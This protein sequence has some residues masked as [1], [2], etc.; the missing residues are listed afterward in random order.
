MV[1]KE[2]H[3]PAQ[4]C[5]RISD[6]LAHFSHPLRLRIICQLYR[7]EKCVGELMEAV[8]EKQSTVSGQLKYLNMA[9]ITTSERRG[10]NVFYRI[11]DERAPR[12]LRHLA[13][14]FGLEAAL[15]AGGAV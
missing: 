13:K 9:G 15:T 4:E 6:Y 10:A 11:Q 1:N 5:R 12:L 7:G 3:L 8:G 14:T 2:F